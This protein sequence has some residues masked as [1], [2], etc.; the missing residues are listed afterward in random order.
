MESSAATVGPWRKKVPVV[1]CLGDCQESRAVFEREVIRKSLANL[2]NSLPA[3]PALPCPHRMHLCRIWQKPGTLWQNLRFRQ[4]SAGLAICWQKVRQKLWAE[5][6]FLADSC[7]KSFGKNSS[8]IRLA[9]FWQT[10][11]QNWFGRRLAEVLLS[12]V[13]SK[14]FKI[15][16]INR[17]AKRPPKEFCQKF[18]QQ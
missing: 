11:W 9:V 13:F 18:C 10:C 1:N 5:L 6:Y 14:L 4:H 17:S 3:C 16:A 7:A 8:G 2:S 12:I 15:S